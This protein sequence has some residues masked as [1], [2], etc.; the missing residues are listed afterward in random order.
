M[1]QYV[2]DNERTI[3]E[4]LNQLNESA[5]FNANGESILPE[6]MDLSTA[7]LTISGIVASL[8][9]ISHTHENKEV[10]DEI[11]SEKVSQWDAAEPNVIT[12]ISAVTKDNSNVIS[13]NGKK[14]TI[15]LTNVGDENVIETISV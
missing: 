1:T 5:G 11:T 9:N 13:V 2:L 6:K 12:E 3:S 14:V 15:D 8:K 4:A 10:L 7:I